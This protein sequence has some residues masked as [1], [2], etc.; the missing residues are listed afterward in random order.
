MEEDIDEVIGV[1]IIGCGN[2]GRNYV[3][4]FV[5]IPG[6]RLVTCCDINHKTLLAIRKRY[7]LVKLTKNYRDIAADPKIDAVVISTPRNHYGLRAHAYFEESMCL[8]KNL[9]AFI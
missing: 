2:W 7:P 5:Q 1:G 3:R 8:W 4:H 9:Y 6:A